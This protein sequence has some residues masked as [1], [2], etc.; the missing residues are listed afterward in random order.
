M[1]FT[2][3]TEE[4]FAFFDGLARDNSKDYF[5]GHHE[6]YVRAVREPA[7][8]LAEALEEEFGPMKVGRPNR[9]VRFS[10]DKSPYKTHVGLVSRSRGPVGHYL[11]LGLEGLSVGAGYHAMSGAQVERYR[12]GVDN[13]RQGPRLARIVEELTAR[14]FDIVGDTLKTHPRGYSGDHPRVHLLRHRSLGAE[15]NVERSDVPLS[16]KLLDTVRADWRATGPLMEW[17]DR[18][19]TS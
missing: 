19:V 11:Q 10:H 5:H 2:G 6:V 13:E 3:F 12:D 14:G 1:D 15:H 4:T 9:D 18:H 16:A 8:A 7:R 17:L